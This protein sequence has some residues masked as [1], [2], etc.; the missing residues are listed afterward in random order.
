MK[1]PELD[2]QHKD[3]VNRESTGSNS[4]LFDIKTL[5]VKTLVISELEV[6]KVCHDP[7]DLL[8]RAVQPALWLIIFGQVFSRARAI[9]TGDIPYLDFMTPGILAQSGLFMAIFT[10]GMTLIWERDLGIVH[11][12]LAAPIPRAAI[13]LGKGIGSGVRCCSQVIVIYLLALLLGVNLNH[14]PIAFLQVVLVVFLG[15]GCF[16]TFSL[17][18][19]C[20]VRSRERFTG[21]GQLITMPLFFASNAIYPISLMPSWLQLISHLNPLTYQVD[22]LRG[23]MLTNGPSIYGFAVDC[24]I[25]LL[26]LIGLTFICG[27]LYP[28]VVM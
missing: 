21:I 1:L 12:F 5:I 13:V 26:T 18:I 25:L 27:R 7:S 17:I 22:A 3:S 11:K 28:R 19:G 4:I 2:I 23:V 14:N 8:I 15:A 20:L 6:R 10:G 16:C 9:P 24:A